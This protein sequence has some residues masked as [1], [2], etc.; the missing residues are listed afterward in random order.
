VKRGPGGLYLLTAGELLDSKLCTGPCL[1]GLERIC[2]CRCKATWHAALVGA[3]VAV[4]PDHPIAV[5]L[6]GG[7][8]GRAGRRQHPHRDR[9]WEP[10]TNAEAVAHF[11]AGL[12]KGEVPSVRR[13]K[14]ELRCG[15]DGAYKIQAYLRG[16][17]D[18]GDGPWMV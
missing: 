18:G 2:E 8:P 7:R 1:L 4:P 3:D 5:A 9:G 14:R 10:V 13:I 16:L 15:Q 17:V 12:A 11:K 6:S